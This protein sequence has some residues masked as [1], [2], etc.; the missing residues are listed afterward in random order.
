MK[1]I[2]E[3]IGEWVGMLRAVGRLIVTGTP[4]ENLVNPDV[5]YERSDVSTRNVLLTGLSILVATWVIAVLLLPGFNAFR[6]RT[7]A[8]ETFTLPPEPRLQISPRTDFERQRAYEEHELH[9]YSWVDRD[10][11]IVAIPI[12]RAIALIAQ[13]GIPPQKAPADLK[14]PIP[15]AGLRET[16]LE[17]NAPPEQR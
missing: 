16:G 11:G 10:K 5:H 3:L 1:T 14:L 6:R 9:R 17:V 4:P 13:R 12:E 15:A 2:N 8:S 7:P